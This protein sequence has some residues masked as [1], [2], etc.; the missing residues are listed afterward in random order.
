MY[1]A[2]VET[3]TGRSNRTPRRYPDGTSTAAQN[4]NNWS[5]GLVISS[6]QL[7]RAPAG[8]AY[9]FEVPST[10][11]VAPCATAQAVD[12]RTLSLATAQ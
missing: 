4:N 5:T 10:G 1:L 11:R 9:T 2:A 6:C 12:S 8:P 3:A 7:P